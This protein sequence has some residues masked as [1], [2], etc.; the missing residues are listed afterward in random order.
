MTDFLKTPYLP[1]RPVRLALIGG[2][3]GAFRALLQ[4]FGV[5]TI[6]LAPIDA[7]D[8]AV[9]NHA[10]LSVFHAGNGIF[11]CSEA[12]AETVQSLQPDK[13]SVVPVG[14]PYPDDCALN[15]AWLRE[16]A[17][18]LGRGSGAP[19]ACFLQEQG[20]RF[21]NVK[22]GYANCSVCP[23]G[24]KALIT[25]DPSICAA[26]EKAGLDVLVVQK[27]DVRLPGHA[28]GF[29][30]GA[31]A[32][33]GPRELVFFGDLSTHRDCAAIKTFLNVQNCVFHDLPGVPLTDI[34]GIVNVK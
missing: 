26:A 32:M 19:L 14:K 21:H 33:I 12:A 28:C 6:V 29:L 22:Q 17:F 4:R 31:S 1:E 23:V 3:T 18:G 27:G 2:G 8:P 30:G 24:E 13:V 5:E 16:D 10:D 15:V 20:I 9:Q 11:F 25:D 34:G 7:D